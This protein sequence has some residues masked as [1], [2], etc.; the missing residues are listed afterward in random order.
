MPGRPADIEQLRRQYLE[1]EQRFRKLLESLPRV[2]VQGYDRERRVIY[3]NA[4]S[5][6]LYGYSEQDAMGQRLED[7]IIP[8]PMRGDVVAAHS[9]WIER[10]EEIPAAELELRHRSGA[11]VPVF[12]HHVMLGEHSEQP[13]MFCIDV[14]L[15]EQ[16][17]AWRDLE[18]A[19]HVDQLTRLPNRQAFERD[20]AQLLDRSAQH[21]RRLAL[22]YIDIDQFSAVNEALGRRHGDR[23]LQGIAGRLRDQQRGEDLLARTSTDEF[24][25]A[26][27]DVHAGCAIDALVDRVQA[28]LRR[29]LS[30]DGH[31]TRLSAGIGVT[32]Y[33]DDLGSAADLL[34]NAE[35]AC[36]QAKQRGQRAVQY[37]EHTF[38]HRLATQHRVQ[39]ELEQALERGELALHYQPQVAAESGRICA[40]E[41]LLR[42]TRHNREPVSPAEFIP[43]AER[44]DLIQRLGAWVLEEACRQLASWRRVGL[45]PPRIDI[46]LS[47]REVHDPHTASHF[48]RCLQRHGL[49]P[50]DIGIE[51]TESVLIDAAPEVLESLRWLHDS[52]VPIAL[53]DFGTGF[54]SLSYL[55][56][57]PVT[58]LK[59]DR[60]FVSGA[61]VD[62]SERAVMEVAVILGQRLDLQVVAEGVE[63][64]E[65][66]Q[67]LRRLR[68]ELIQGFHLYRPMPADAMTLLLQQQRD[69][70]DAQP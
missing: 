13:V 5:E 31:D 18:Q 64:E 7:L 40:M 6:R 56:S 62:D 34:R 52:G 1:S 11:P 33:P 53:D 69:I 24:V 20:L 35:V 16:H 12:S 37:F 10:G 21:G 61:L 30:I 49:G 19:R 43:V 42:W 27:A 36:H 46:N 28:A 8:A 14:D 59:I 22:L 68:C 25:L 50:G 38:R 60:S 15:G 57:F 54:S 23:L 39:E 47:A 17:R 2:A 41:A 67:L 63:T 66:L 55:S 45:S 48:H 51:L 58:S 65:Q 9:A 70:P 44:S 29:P 26:F 32:V 3:W 4:A